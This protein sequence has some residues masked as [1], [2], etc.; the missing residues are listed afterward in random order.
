MCCFKQPGAVQRHA[1]CGGQ[2]L[3]R[4]AALPLATSLHSVRISSTCRGAVP[5]LFLQ[6][7]E[8]L[9]STLSTRLGR[10]VS[11]SAA[12]APGA[13]C[14]TSAA[15]QTLLLQIMQHLLRAS[16]HT[17]DISVYNT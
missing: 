6:E 8:P 12:N 5:L 17:W 7:G 14:L 11:E 3:G 9:T 16:G 4:V 1:V 2:P 15:A 10:S 13:I